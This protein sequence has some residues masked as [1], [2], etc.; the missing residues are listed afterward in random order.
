MQ[1]HSLYLNIL[2]LFAVFILI[3]MPSPSPVVSAPATQDT[4]GTSVEQRY[5]AMPLRPIQINPSTQSFADPV[6]EPHNMAGN[7]ISYY[8]PNYV[9]MAVYSGYKVENR[10]W[11]LYRTEKSLASYSYPVPITNTNWAEVFPRLNADASWLVYV[12]DQDRNDEIYKMRLDGS[13]STRLTRHDATDTHPVFSPDGAKI[14]FASNRHGNY[15]IFTMSSSGANITKLTNI[16]NHDI[17]PDWSPDG[18]KIAWIRRSES[19]GY[20]MVMNADGTGGET[21]LAALHYG[22]RPAWSLDGKQ[23]AFEY[24][25]DGDGWLDL[26]IINADGSGL[27]Q[28]PVSKDPYT[29]LS[30]SGWYGGPGG[31]RLIISQIHYTFNSSYGW[32]VVEANAHA[33]SL[34]QSSWGELENLIPSG[35][36]NW[37]FYADA[38]TWD[39]TAPQVQIINEIPE[40][41]QGTVRLSF[42]IR[43]ATSG[44]YEIDVTSSNPGNN[45]WER[46]EY[47]PD[48]NGV[49]IGEYEIRTYYSAPV[50]VH[51]SVTDNGNNAAVPIIL[52][53]KIYSWNG[54]A[55][56]QDA[57]ET[58]LDGA[59]ISGSSLYDEP[60]ETINGVADLYF[61]SDLSTGSSID[62]SITHTGF[63]ALPGQAWPTGNESQ[64]LAVLPPKDN[65]ITNG[66]F[67]DSANLLT[68]WQNE[69]ELLA[70]AAFGRYGGNAAQLGFECSTGFCLTPYEKVPLVLGSNSALA[71]DANGDGHLLSLDKYYYRNST[72]FWQEGAS[73]NSS[74]HGPVRVFPD[75]RPFTYV[76]GTQ[77][78]FAYL[79]S[80]DQWVYEPVP[81]DIFDLL[82]DDSG[83]VHMLYRQNSVLYYRKRL[84]T[85]AWQ[86]PLTIT[87]TF[88]YWFTYARLV[89]GT[90][91]T[92]HIAYRDT[93]HN[94]ESVLYRQ[95]TPSGSLSALETLS[96][97]ALPA[98]VNPFQLDLKIDADGKL[99]L[100]VDAIDYLHYWSRSPSGAWSGPLS[101]DLSTVDEYAD[102]VSGVVA[103]NGD[104]H[105]Y[106]IYRN[107]LGLAEIADVMKKAGENQFHL[108]RLLADKKIMGLVVGFDVTGLMHML[109]NNQFTAP[110][111]LNYQKQQVLDGP[112]ES[113]L[114]QTASLPLNMYAPTLSFFYRMKD[115]L[116]NTLP[117]FRLSLTPQGGSPVLLKALTASTQINNWQHVWF[118]L[119]PWLG[120]TVKLAFEVPHVPGQNEAMVMLD[121]ITLGGWTTPIVTGRTPGRVSYPVGSNIWVEITGENLMSGAKVW[122]GETQSPE[123]VWVSATQLR[124]RVP[125]GLNYGA[126]RLRVEN[127]GGI[128]VYAPGG[129]VIG[130]VVYIP[131]IGK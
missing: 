74:N 30:M 90:D 52:N 61:Y 13:E 111:F 76:S 105:A 127:P 102:L 91:G 60:V 48:A 16:T 82:S 36:G 28:L 51:F 88:T 87:D 122:F 104:I 126:Y 7:G 49:F 67:E 70:G 79:N 114:S 83:Q 53:M 33:V 1:K 54:Q 80:S 130:G 11:D 41:S 119:S 57:R 109:W 24:D 19:I 95:I 97:F 103:S 62:T 42:I 100:F 2:R 110:N 120:Q 34:D 84:A 131:R 37:Y 6:P 63:G 31:I 121:E 14:A 124:V 32:Y 96:G 58:P 4:P 68:G 78:S 106:Y 27:E 115:N 18:T 25:G 129:L 113:V 20:L 64:F 118:D 85:G 9:S 17:E 43:D 71:I 12:S 21:T 10:H 108:N 40:Y 35:Y 66:Y 128:Y 77:Y 46:H 72:G 44:S 55:Y 73:L 65:L 101:Q 8:S 99:H 112:A 5:A 45:L 98:V 117:D 50:T 94:Y 38:Y 92:V 107:D 26:G 89:V 75:G 56:V 125:Q 59:L 15:E 81:G 23:L 93:E 47:V 69:G 116:T 22:G 3:L 29:D 86:P 123:V 39:V